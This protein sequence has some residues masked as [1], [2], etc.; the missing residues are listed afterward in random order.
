M[1]F[2]FNSH[3]ATERPHAVPDRLYLHLPPDW[4]G[5]LRCSGVRERN[6][7][8]KRTIATGKEND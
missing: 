6:Q 5:G 3:E 8:K 2:F 1:V 7:S 4:G